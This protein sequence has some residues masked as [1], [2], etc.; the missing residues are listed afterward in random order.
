MITEKLIEDFKVLRDHCIIIRRDYNTYND[1]FFSGNDDVLIKAASIFFNDIADILARDWKL[2]VCKLM[3]RAETTYKKEVFE[4]ITI[5]LINSQLE[6]CGLLS[7]DICD[8]SDRILKYGKEVKPARD[9]RLAHFDR[10][11]Q[12]KGV[13][14][15]ETTEEELNGFLN[16]IQSYCDLVGNTIGLGLLD[17]SAS[18]FSGDALDLLKVLR[19]H[20]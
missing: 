20:A 3:D 9:K 11:H 18:G 1:L 15:G 4:N 8:I 17:F 5:E 16:D 2:Q 13:L 19:K 14:L 12:V 6:C 7:K 10:E